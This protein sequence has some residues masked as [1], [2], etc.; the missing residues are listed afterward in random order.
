MKKETIAL[1]GVLNTPPVT[2]AMPTPHVI[3]IPI[4]DGAALFALASRETK[5]A[6]KE[7]LHVLGMCNARVLQPL[8]APILSPAITPVT[9]NPRALG[10]KPALVE[11]QTHRPPLNVQRKTQSGA[12][13]A[14]TP[15]VTK[16]ESAS[17][18]KTKNHVAIT[19]FPIQ[20]QVAIIPQ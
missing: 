19:L 7:L 15:C 12:L 3:S 8:T 17:T 16:A 14:E 4:G 6:V 13:A 2:N 1:K 5:Q 18:M 10:L 11:P 9:T 20:T